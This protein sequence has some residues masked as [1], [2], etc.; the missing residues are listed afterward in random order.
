MEPI[1]PERIYPITEDKLAPY[2]GKPVCAVLHNGDCIQGIISEVRHGQIFFTTGAPPGTTV[3]GK[4][5]AAKQGKK[6]GSRS[7][8][9]TGHKPNADVSSWGYPGFPGFYPGYSGSFA[10]SIALIALLFAI[11]F[12]GYPLWL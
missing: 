11:P 4:A 5:K 9:S 7:T 12:I 8:R 2:I 3:S 10:L 1:Y 6:T